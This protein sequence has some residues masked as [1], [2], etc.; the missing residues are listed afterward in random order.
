M[1]RCA[2]SACACISW[3]PARPSTCIPGRRRRAGWPSPRPERRMRTALVLL[4]SIACLAAAAAGAREPAGILRYGCDPST[5]RL[6]LS[7]RD[8]GGDHVVWGENVEL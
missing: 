5:P 3:W 8:A 4:L 7:V 1:I 2:C 6:E